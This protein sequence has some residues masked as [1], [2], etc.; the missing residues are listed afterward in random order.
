M[1][2]E[3]HYWATSYA[4]LPSDL[5]TRFPF[6]KYLSVADEWDTAEMKALCSRIFKYFFYLVI[7]DIIENKVTFKM[8]PGTRA[9]L[10]MAPVTGE[11][12]AKARQNGAFADVDFL[13]SNFTG[14][15]L[16]LRYTNR[17]G[18]WAKR[19][20]VSAKYRDKITEMTN[21]GET[22]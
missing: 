18:K 6:K 21:A 1:I 8:P 17:Y 2:Y 5:Y 15:K 12:F 9:W 22:W 10:E 20:Y 3:P 19:I 13:A 16:Q 4:L 14:Y 7:K 11:E